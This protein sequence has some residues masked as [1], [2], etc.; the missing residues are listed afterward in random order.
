MSGIMFADDRQ[1]VGFICYY[2]SGA[3]LSEMLVLE[4]AAIEAEFNGFEGE[5]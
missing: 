5:N 3:Q 4:A 2:S 1:A